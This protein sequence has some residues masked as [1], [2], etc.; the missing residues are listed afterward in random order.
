[1]C[2]AHANTYD[3]TDS[4]RHV[5]AY[6]DRDSDI[7]AYTHGHSHCYTNSRDAYTNTNF[8]LHRRPGTV[9]LCGQLSERG[10]RGSRAW[11]QWHLSLFGWRLYRWSKQRG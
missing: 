8:Y 1:M 10:G 3:N 4:H 11:E 7:H 2:N 5:Y 9:E 6:T